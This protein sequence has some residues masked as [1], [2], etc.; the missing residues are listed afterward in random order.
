MDEDLKYNIL[1][2]TA[3]APRPLSCI[4]HIRTRRSCHK[5]ADLPGAPPPKACDSNRYKDWA[6][7][8]D[9]Y[10]KVGYPRGI[11]GAM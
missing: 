11:M 7:G 9:L 8:G 4:S 1:L 6:C 10:P 2:Y 3:L 5:C